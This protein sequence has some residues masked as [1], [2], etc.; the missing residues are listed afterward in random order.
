MIDHWEVDSQSLT[1][2]EELGEGAF[3]KVYRGIL[4]EL[5]TL[6]L[7]P[8]VIVNAMK[9]STSKES[10]EFIVAVKMLHGE[11]MRQYRRKLISISVMSSRP[12]SLHGYVNL[13]KSSLQL[14]SMGPLSAIP[15][16]CSQPNWPHMELLMQE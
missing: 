12:N 10:K 5:N 6:P 1:L 13:Q 11:H 15:P 7:L 2:E 8:S 9:K 14:V 16:I 3:G 4:K